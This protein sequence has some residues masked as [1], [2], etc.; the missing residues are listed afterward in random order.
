MGEGALASLVIFREPERRWAEIMEGL[1]PVAV[2]GSVGQRL[3]FGAV[4]AGQKINNRERAELRMVQEAAARFIDPDD[5]E[6]NAPTLHGI[7][8]G[9]SKEVQETVKFNTGSSGQKPDGSRRPGE[10][11][12]AALKE[13]EIKE[14]Q[15]LGRKA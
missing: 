2:P 6:Q 12:A 10:G 8:A 5:L 4:L 9:L 11:L 14:K 15:T 13:Q 7:Y 1:L 3:V